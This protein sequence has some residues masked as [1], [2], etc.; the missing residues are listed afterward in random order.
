MISA[1]VFGGVP[2]TAVRKVLA[3]ASVYVS[4][5]LLREYREVPLTLEGEGK[6]NHRQ[7]KALISGVAAFVAE[8]KIVYPVR[9]FMLCRDAADNMLLECCFAAKTDYLVTG[10]KD[11][12]DM[13]VLPFDLRILRPRDYLAV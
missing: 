6:I 1:F 12:L 5:E 7:L 11:L 13:N 9:K 10:D 4:P 2:A 8:A 3:E